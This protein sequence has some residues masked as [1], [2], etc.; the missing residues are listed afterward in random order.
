[1]DLSIMTEIF[2]FL[3][4]TR[5]V[6]GKIY[7]EE[8]SSTKPTAFRSSAAAEFAENW[9]IC[10]FE[11]VLLTSLRVKILPLDVL[12]LRLGMKYSQMSK[13]PL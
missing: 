7:E 1:M 5:A 8:G 3:Q 9:V 10:A 4:K 12:P 11:K 13:A 6:R 2:I